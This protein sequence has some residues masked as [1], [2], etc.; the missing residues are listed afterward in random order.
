MAVYLDIMHELTALIGQCEG[1]K[2][3][4]R[5]AGRI[6][7]T[8]TLQDGGLGAA[9]FVGNEA[10]WHLDTADTGL[11]DASCIHRSLRT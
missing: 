10:P 6:E 5:V 3:P 11:A 2:D 1:G 7:G 8:A 4:R 9:P